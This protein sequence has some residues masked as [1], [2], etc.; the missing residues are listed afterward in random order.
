MTVAFAGFTDYG[1][2]DT[3][4][5][6]EGWFNLQR[7]VGVKE[8]FPY[9]SHM[10]PTVQSGVTRTV[11]IS[12]GQ[13]AAH[14]VWSDM[15]EALDVVL[16]NQASGRR[17]DCIAVERVFG[18]DAASTGTRIVVIKGGS[19][20]TIPTLIR[21]P[22]SAWRTPIALVEVESGPSGATLGELIDLRA[23][24]E[25]GGSYAI[26]D[27]MTLEML[28]NI[29]V[30]A[31]NVNTGN[32]FVRTY[33]SGGARQWLSLVTRP[34]FE[35]IQVVGSFG[36]SHAGWTAGATEF[37]STMTRDGRRRTM[38]LEQRRISG[39]V[40]TASHTGH[41]ANMPTFQVVAADRP[42]SRVVA[43]AQYQNDDNVDFVAGA[44]VVSNGDVVLTSL[45]PNGVLN[46][47]GA[48]DWSIRVSAEWYV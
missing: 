4:T 19:S 5:D 2:P 26:F 42:A 30:I 21:T 12:A 43:N 16:D 11:R 24:R 47:R 27:D 46:G 37:S 10:R 20:R 38:Y 25:H 33:N 18:A 29:G 44:M 23:L 13:S 17:Y 32:V 39:G 9:F 35:H 34:Q 40:I 28:D 36:S 41:I 8:A 45:T 48:G 14:G 22:G 3:V 1:F 31:H 6:G 15:D 7:A